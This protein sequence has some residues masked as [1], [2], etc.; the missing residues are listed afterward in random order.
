MIDNPSLLCAVCGLRF[1][2]A[3]G[4][5][6]C[7]AGLDSCRCGARDWET[8]EAGPVCC[9]CGTGPGVYEEVDGED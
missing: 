5:C 4:E 8:T 6:S 3:D 2:A 1:Q 9:A 7:T